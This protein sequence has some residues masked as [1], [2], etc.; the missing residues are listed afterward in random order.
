MLHHRLT[1]ESHVQ[2]EFSNSFDACAI[3]RV[4]LVSEVISLQLEATQ[5]S[6]LSS[7]FIW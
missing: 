6:L 4:T 3:I 7:T 5:K 2:S 1:D